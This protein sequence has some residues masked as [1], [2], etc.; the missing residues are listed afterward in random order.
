MELDVVVDVDACLAPLGILVALAR[1][2]RERRSVELLEPA[3]AASGGLLEGPFVERGESW[4]DLSSELIEGPLR[5]WKNG[6]L[7]QVIQLRYSLS[8]R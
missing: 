8:P 4:C 7:H 5:G 1:Q 6:S 2:R 3:A